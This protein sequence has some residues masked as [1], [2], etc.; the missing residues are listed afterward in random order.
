MPTF[1]STRKALVFALNASNN[2]SPAQPFMSKAMNDGVAVPR[3][4]QKARDEE[5]ERAYY[6]DIA[7]RAFAVGFKLNAE[8]RLML[9]GHV[10]KTFARLDIDHQ[11]I[12]KGLLVE[13]YAPCACRRPCCSGRAENAQWRAAVVGICEML[14]GHE[15]KQRKPGRR[16]F[17]TL[18]ELRRAVVESYFH[19]L[20]LSITELAEA[21]KL[22]FTTAA[23][24]KGWIAEIL[25]ATE[26]EAWQ[27]ADALLDAAGITGSLNSQD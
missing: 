12:L 1:D 26:N 25:A 21:T 14:A 24:H 20:P 4:K 8:E 2:A 18:P 9:S 22:S 7:H 6:A 5:E 27:E 10:L 16:S 3:K 17:S 13:P 15:N 11:S 23:K 19:K